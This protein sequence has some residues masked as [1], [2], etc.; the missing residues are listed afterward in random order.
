[1]RLRGMI[2]SGILVALAIW[3]SE[4]QTRSIDVSLGG[5]TTSTS[6]AASTAPSNRNYGFN[7][8]CIFTPNHWYLRIFPNGSASFGYGSGPVDLDMIP[9]GTF[10]FN[11][12]VDELRARIDSGA[13]FG[14]DCTVAFVRPN[15]TNTAGQ[16]ISDASIVLRWFDTV[17]K[18]KRSPWS[19]VDRCWS[20]Q[21]PTTRSD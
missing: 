3:Y 7:E 15:T 2:V 8:V 11:Q 14:R 5:G 19:Q 6:N 16:P 17:H 12:V 4:A 10:Q 20:R 1:M 13:Q 18:V 21:P 9:A